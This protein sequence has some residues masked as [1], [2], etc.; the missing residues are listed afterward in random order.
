MTGTARNANAAVGSASDIPAPAPNDGVAEEDVQVGGFGD[1][2]SI[3]APAPADGSA[4][5][6]VGSFGPSVLPPG[7]PAPAPTDGAAVKVEGGFFGD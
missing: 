4:T 2:S 5:S 1:D 3:P 6:G 7:F